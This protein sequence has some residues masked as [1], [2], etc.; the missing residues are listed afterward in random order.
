VE[1]RLYQTA[2]SIEKLESELEE[3]S[4]GRRK[5]RSVKE[6]EVRRG[7][8]VRGVLR[9]K[10]RGR[11]ISTGKGLRT[12]FEKIR[13]KEEERERERERERR[14]RKTVKETWLPL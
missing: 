3:G 5:V 10:S 6:D 4:K 13:V 1:E 12:A 11:L 14:N 9:P 7:K 8:R 2:A